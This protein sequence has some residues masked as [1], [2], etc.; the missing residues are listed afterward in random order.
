MGRKIIGFLIIIFGALVLAGLVYFVFVGNFSFAGIFD[1]FMSKPATTEEPSNITQTPVKVENT[2]PK[3][4]KKDPVK[5][6]ANNP[7][8]IEVE[9]ENEVQPADPQKFTKVDLMRM[10]SSFAERF[11]SF[12]N[13]SNFSNIKDL[14]IYMSQRMK[15]WA[16]QYIMEKSQEMGSTD[17]Y[18]GITTKAIAEEVKDLDED[19]GQAIV[20]V[21]TRRREAT[22]STSNT[23]NVFN[24][25][26]I[27]LFT[28]EGGAWKVDDAN[29][30]ERE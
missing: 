9:D 2:D 17:L 10:A 13:H 20:E 18:Y 25:K 28:N 30:Q 8:A 3:P 12:S 6:I 27:I 16:D 22:S 7:V 15:K 11:G 5:I 19:T 26:I 14:K 1:K 4:I 23:S 21:S 24:Q 29:W